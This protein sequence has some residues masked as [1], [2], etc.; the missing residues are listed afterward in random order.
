MPRLP[1][2]AIRASVFRASV[3]KH[4]GGGER[5]STRPARPRPF[6]LCLP[7]CVILAALPPTLHRHCC[8]AALR[9]TPSGRNVPPLS[10][11]RAPWRQIDVDENEE[12]A[13]QYNIQ[14]MPTFKVMDGSG[15]QC[16]H[17]GVPV[18]PEH[19]P[20]PFRTYRCTAATAAALLRLAAAQGKP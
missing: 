4:A 13:A 18:Q 2:Q 17:F 20:F 6:S 11:A 9:L 7:A 5:R 19:P 1:L 10:S 8:T 14:A 3:F 16:V 12:V 15:E